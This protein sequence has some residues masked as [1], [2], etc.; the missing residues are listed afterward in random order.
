MKQDVSIELNDKVLFKGLKPITIL[1]TLPGTTHRSKE[2]KKRLGVFM[3]KSTFLRRISPAFLASGLVQDGDF[4]DGG[5][6][7]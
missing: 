2:K 5:L 1:E 7:T 3:V 6:D 4:P